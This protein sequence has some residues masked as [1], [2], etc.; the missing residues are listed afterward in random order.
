MNKLKTLLI[1]LFTVNLQGELSEDNL[2]KLFLS[3]VL[4][5][6]LVV[7]SLIFVY[8]SISNNNYTLSY[9]FLF[10]IAVHVFNYITLLYTRKLRLNITVSISSIILLFF[11]ILFKPGPNGLAYMWFYS[12]PVISVL[13][14]D[15]KYAAYLNSFF[16]IIIF[17]IFHLFSE[18]LP[19]EYSVELKLRFLLSFISLSVLLFTYAYINTRLNIRNKDK[20]YAKLDLANTRK[21][22]LSS[23]SSKIK[24]VS[25]EINELTNNAEN[26]SFTNE[27]K[28]HIVEL[29]NSSD[30]LVSVMSNVLEVSAFINDD[31]RA[32]QNF[33]IR[34]LINNTIDIFFN[35]EYNIHVIFDDD[36][37][38]LYIGNP[39]LLKQI[40]FNLM[41]NI[42]KNI[43]LVDL[44]IK[45]NV[46]VKEE[47]EANS[48]QLKMNI[49][50]SQ[51]LSIN[52]L[53]LDKTLGF[54]EKN[55]GSLEIKNE[56]D[57]SLVILNL[58]LQKDIYKYEFKE[59]FKNLLFKLDSEYVRTLNKFDVEQ[60][61][62][63]SALL[64]S[65]KF[66]SQISIKSELEGHIKNIDLASNWNEVSK[67]LSYNNYNFIFIDFE[68]DTKLALDLV[69][70]IK[71][72]EIALGY[73]TT[74]I[75][76]N[77]DYLSNNINKAIQSGVDE[78]LSK[79]FELG[80]LIN[81][82]KIYYTNS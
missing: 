67:I 44:K 82:L 4:S 80:R 79:P 5:F 81:K 13:L 16:L 55:K 37:N 31:K 20:F 1:D 12:I 10:I 47:Q 33:N 9:I 60:L 66:S 49:P 2:I 23:L 63:M 42:K 77:V 43:N 51:D 72:N 75:A 40:I 68:D 78:Y 25:N 15:F 18:Y 21:E 54:V 41:D 62:K 65:E 3:N 46:S 76:I 57:Y 70:N 38:S 73:K 27:Q 32:L 35:K 28:I 53:S 58:E 45:I 69:K 17:I 11:F 34:L 24:D 64:V 39:I 29:H 59:K 19:L 30:S 71:E 7:V 61:K 8:I 22:F 6:S 52:N 74:I 14:L 26:I 56:D 50:T 36:N 48:V